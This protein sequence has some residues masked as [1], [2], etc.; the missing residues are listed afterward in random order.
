M[1]LMRFPAVIFDT[2]LARDLW[3]HRLQCLLNLGQEFRAPADHRELLDDW[4][5]RQLIAA[6]CSMLSGSAFS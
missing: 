3:A 5:R 2:V 4:Q 1:Y 6:S